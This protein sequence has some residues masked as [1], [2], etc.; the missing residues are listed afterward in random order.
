MNQLSPTFCLF[1][2]KRIDRQTFWESIF[3]KC[4]LALFKTDKE[5]KKYLLKKQD[6]NVSKLLAFPKNVR[7]DK[8][9][10]GS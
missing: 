10:S 1:S 8:V 9:T 4:F 5:N 3:H 6:E 7:Y 2:K